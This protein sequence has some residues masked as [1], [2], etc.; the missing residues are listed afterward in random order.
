MDQTQ[1]KKTQDDIEEIPAMKNELL[2]KLNEPVTTA[3]NIS[4][5]ATMNSSNDGAS[6][7][8]VVLGKDS[9][10]NV[11]ASLLASY[12]DIQQKSMAVD[13]K[14]MISSLSI[15]EMQQ[16]LT[17]LLQENVKL[18]ETLKQN[19]VSMKQQFQ[20]LAIWQEEV[21]KVHQNH[22]QKF[23]ETR[24]LISQLKQENT[25][26]QTKLLQWQQIENMGFEPISAISES[27]SISI[28]DQI[29][30]QQSMLS[31]VM[32]SKMDIEACKQYTTSEKFTEKGLY[33]SPDQLKVEKELESAMKSLNCNSCETSEQIVEHQECSECSVKQQEIACLK[34]SIALLQ[35]RL[36]CTLSS[37]SYDLSESSS[38]SNRQKFIQSMK[39]YND[40]YHELTACFVG[41]IERFPV[42]EKNL[43]EITDI[44]MVLDDDPSKMQLHQ[45]REKLCHFCKHLADEQVKIITD[46]QILVKSQ[47]QFQKIL[48]DYNSIL[49]EL[50]ITI[51]ENAKL[52]V[53]KDNT[54]RESLQKSGEMERIKQDRQLFEEKKRTFDQ[55]KNHLEEEKKSLEKQKKSL[56]VE[57]D[58]LYDERKLLAQ[59]KISLNEEKMSLDQQSQLY[60]D[61]EKSLQNEKKTLQHQFEKLLNETNF[62]KQELEEKNE[63][64]KEVLEHLAQSTEEINLLRSQLT[65][66]EEDFQHEKKLKEA[67]LEEKSK[68]DVELQKQVEYNK[69][70]QESA[71]IY[72][73]TSSNVP[74]EPRGGDKC[75]RHARIEKSTTQKKPNYQLFRKLLRNN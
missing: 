46:R 66:Y 38:D 74:S 6:L 40:I 22:K 20:T 37:I 7:S 75:N 70:L 10:E 54:T 61:C 47:N 5:M 59:E 39:Q 55:E 31:K 12:V 1:D 21:M 42:I 35:Q 44:L 53:L 71:D 36:Q 27:T 18:K 33:K 41:Q 49:Y 73:H 9:M 32:I 48:S 63:E 29:E 19:N 26:L 14:T 65:L 52:N 30:F 56:D 17:E 4:S 15:D 3:L 34:E 50:E 16:R 45:Y 24:K 67:L 51:D 60:E 72:K 57:R 43:K 68:L 62:L 28:P 13:Y 8:F 64:F 11:Q 69:Q 23:A 2:F 25:D 58:S